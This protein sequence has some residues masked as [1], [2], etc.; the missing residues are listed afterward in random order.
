[1]HAAAPAADG[2]IPHFAH[3]DLHHLWA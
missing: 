2:G 3:V 1:V